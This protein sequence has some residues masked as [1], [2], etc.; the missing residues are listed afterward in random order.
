MHHPNI[1]VRSRVYYLF[2]KFIKEDRNEIPTE[3]VISLLND[4]RDVLVIEVTLPELENPQEQNLLTEA[5]NAAG[6]FDKQLYLFETVG[7]LDSL[8]FKNQDETTAVLQS[9][10]QPLLDELES[11][12]KAI[13]N[14]QDVMQIVKVHHVM[15]ALG[16]IAKGFP[17]LP[18]P[19]P[20]GYILPPISIFR[21]MTQAIVVSLG[22][23]CVFKPVREAARFAF[24]RMV[25]TTGS[26][27]TDFIPAFMTSLLS[28]FEPTEL[29]DFMNFLGLLMHRLTTQI[30]DVVNQLVAPLHARILELLAEPVSGTDDKITHTDTKKAYLTFL[31]NIVQNKLQGVFLTDANKPQFVQLL[32]SLIEIA[33]N[34]SDPASQRLAFAFLGRCVSAW[35]PSQRA[36]NGD[37]SLPGFETFIYDRLIPMAFRVPS[38]PTFN[39]RDGQILVVSQTRS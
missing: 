13:K 3:V 28:Q 17:D 20:E 34:P 12:L 6:V 8:L 18:Q 29:V 14:E 7:L 1:N 39:I 24:A 26:A 25:A 30:F 16:S 10:V 33:E 22:A 2:Y 23:M 4:I 27:I 37:G 35:G 11:N 32:E 36:A 21:Q 15:M 5:I 9:F 31:S 38:S 19:V